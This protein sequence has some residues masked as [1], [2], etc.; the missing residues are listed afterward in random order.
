M[1]FL[2]TLLC[3]LSRVSVITL[4]STIATPLVAD[5]LQPHD[6][7][8]SV[9]I[10]HTIVVTGNGKD[11]G[12][13]L[14]HVAKS[15]SRLNLTLKETPASIDVISGD[16][17]K[18]RGD[19][20]VS[21]AVTRVAGITSLATPGNGGTALSA[22]GFTGHGSVMQLFDG[23][24]FAVG[25]GTVTF[26][27]D[28]WSVERIEVLRG[29]AS[30]LYGQGAIGGAI[31]VIPKKPDYSAETEIKV[32]AGEFNTQRLAIGSQGAVATNV[33]YR[34]DV[35]HYRSDGWLDGGDN[36]NLAFGGAVQW[37]VNDALSVTLAHDNGHQQPDRYFGTPLI[38][39][40][41]KTAIRDINY[42]AR[43]NDINYRDKWTR[44][45]TQWAINENL[46]L[47]DQVYYLESKRH[48]RNA[49]SYEWSPDT[50]QVTVSDF[51]EIYHDQTQIGNR[52]DLKVLGTL[53]GL[54]HESVIGVDVNTIDFQH[55]NNSPYEGS[56]TVALHDS[57]TVDFI[58]TAGTFPRYQ[59]ETDQTAVFAENR[60]HLSEKLTLVA[61]IRQDRATFSRRDLIDN[62]SSFDKNFDSR[63]W[64]LGTVFALT[65]DTSLYAQFSTGTDPVGSLI[66]TSAR[67]KDF[68]ISRGQ[69]IEIG[70]KQ[71]FWQQ[72]GEWT[73]AFYDITKKDL[74][75]RAVNDPSKTVQIGQQSSQGLETNVAV[76]FMK[77]W[78]INANLAVLNAQFDDFS[79]SVSN[80]AV[81]RK[82]NVP[83]NVPEKTTNAWLDWQITDAWRASTGARYVDERYSDNANQRLL[84]DYTVWDASVEWQ[85]NA[86]TKVGAQL[87]NLANEDYVVA[88]YGGQQ[89][90]LGQPRTFEVY[91]HWV[92]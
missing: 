74:L 11:T 37:D 12:L 66:T 16:T 51:L 38:D 7:D 81:S 73:L 28:T 61:G 64:R 25:A 3:T 26:P 68:D 22:R 59:T 13:S 43:D 21:E 92:N 62:A 60:L 46:L 33:A 45:I 4:T 75:T 27:F 67:Q 87:H 6:D 55:T 39:N 1:Q 71:S 2:P 24:Q 77:R 84:P 47:N 56:T 17:L 9:M 70:S 57:L 42:N 82:G 89:W 76:E 35:S 40:R 18:Q 69:Q 88:A 44:L 15:G 90:L 48:W 91:L 20:T 5:T 72:K 23:T 86:M 14:D 83:T 8:T 32:G 19:T 10:L 34:A 53:L 41:L 54:P 49:E 58:N 36:E 78:T 65:P 79:E 29:P 30:V 80:V 52:T 50:G 31:N 85:L 63:S